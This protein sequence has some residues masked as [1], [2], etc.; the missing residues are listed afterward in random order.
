V[1][2]QAIHI[3][4]IG[5]LALTAAV[6]AI[7]G[8]VIGTALNTGLGEFNLFAET[9]ATVDAPSFVDPYR[10]FVVAPAADAPSFV[11]PYREFVVA[12]A[13]DAPSFVDPYREFV[14]ATLAQ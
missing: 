11:D 14:E 10:E 13:A 4:R 9:P 1:N 2:T 12:P 3:V 7:F 8:V 6:A 5:G